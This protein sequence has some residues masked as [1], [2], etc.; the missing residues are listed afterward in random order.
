MEVARALRH[1]RT[2][3]AAMLDLDRFKAYNDLHG[4]QAGDRLLRDT[5]AAWQGTLRGSDLLARLGGDE[6]GLLLPDC[7]AEGARVI[8][9]RLQRVTPP[10]AGCSAGLAVLRPGESPA[11][12]VA[13]ADAALYGVKG[14]GRGGVAVA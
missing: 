7:D 9:E 6:F 8:V 12:L 3:C 10:G 14:G 4:H 5:T 13:R 11:A 2:L 1:G